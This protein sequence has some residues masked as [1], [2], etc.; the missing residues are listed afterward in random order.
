MLV[1]PF[2]QL[3]SNQKAYQREDQYIS[4]VLKDI[5]IK[6]SIA[7]RGSTRVAVFFSNVATKLKLNTQKKPRD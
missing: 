3:D 1:D 5:N 6:E 4:E 7:L 2:N